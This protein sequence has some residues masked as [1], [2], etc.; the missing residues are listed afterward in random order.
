M[1]NNRDQ[2]NLFTGDLQT[3]PNVFGSNLAT[4]SRSSA[5]MVLYFL[6]NSSKST[7]HGLVLVTYR[8]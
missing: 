6:T 3:L 1:D 7:P 8:L 4:V 5:D 2:V